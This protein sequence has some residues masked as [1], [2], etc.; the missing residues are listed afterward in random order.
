MEGQKTRQKRNHWFYGRDSVDLE[1]MNTVEFPMALLARQ[2]PQKLQRTKTLEFKDSIEDSSTGERVLR[3]LVISANATSNL[4]NYWDQD[5]LVALKCYTNRVH[6][7]TSE[8]VPFTLYGI[9]KLMRLNPDGKNCRRLATSLN[10]W[11]GLR[12]HY[13]HWRIGDVWHHPK[14]FGIIQDYDLTRLKQRGRYQP[15]FPQEFAWSRI[16]FDSVRDPKKTK[17]FD[18]EFYFDLKLPSSRRLYNFGD[19]RLYQQKYYSK[20]ITDFASEKM[21]LVRGQKPSKYRKLLTPAYD[22]LVAK[23]FLADLSPEKRFA[24]RNN[25]N[26]YINFMRGPG[27]KNHSQIS[28]PT[29]LNCLSH[30]QALID[31]GCTA[32]NVKKLSKLGVQKPEMELVA[33]WFDWE[34]EHKTEIPNPGGW[35]YK[36][37]KEGWKPPKNFK[38]PSQSLLEAKSS[39]KRNQDRLLAKET[40]R[41]EEEARTNIKEQK[42]RQFLD[43]RNSFPRKERMLREDEALALESPL[44]R[45]AIERERERNEVGLYHQLL[46]EKHL[47]PR[48]QG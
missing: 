21:G 28:V 17:P 4:P 14:A 25:G 35:I 38:S 47:L 36:A 2:I 37:C 3:T 46:W 1:E 22:E 23:R 39:T 40:R 15:D 18:A 6:R 9:L 13:S 29:Q 48:E 8:V 41:L 20:I 31:R 30:E 16:F 33:E 34:V 12:L 32:T 11:Q 43:F 10:N 42:T 27:R 26:L 7:W 5:A 45:H 24:Y 19:K 44:V